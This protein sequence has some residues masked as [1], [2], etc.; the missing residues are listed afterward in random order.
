MINIIQTEPS[1][2][3]LNKNYYFEPKL[4]SRAEANFWAL[5]DLWWK[6]VI[7]PS[8]HHLGRYVFDENLHRVVEE[9]GYYESA[10]NAYQFVGK[11][12]TATLTVGFYKKIHQIACAH[13]D[14]FR[15]NT[16][17]F[18][19]QVG[20]FSRPRSIDS[21]F[22]LKDL[23]ASLPKTEQDKIFDELRNHQISYSLGDSVPSYLSEWYSEEEI[24]IMRRENIEGNELA[25]KWLG[26]F[27]KGLHVKVKKINT[28][29]EEI[30]RSLG[31]GAIPFAVVTLE[32]EDAIYTPGKTPHIH[33][34]Y[35]CE[36]PENLV[37]AAI[38]LFN[39]EI[40][41]VS[42]E[43]K[44]Q[45]IAKLFQTLE[46]LHCYCDGQGRTDLILL[47]KLLC[48]HGFTP[49]IIDPLFASSTVTLDEWVICLKNGMERWKDSLPQN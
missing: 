39:E 15:T 12:L 42:E 19:N 4:K 20:T 9:K 2:S 47:A 16:N 37:K 28:E 14:G 23:F 46:W 49:A 44:L 38:D 43:A 45:A 32:S 1:G 25:A 30:N 10:K 17:L 21:I 3:D 13:F 41:T 29:I 18:A 26:N 31:G 22:P 27:V 40:G 7:D 24:E 36:H 48:Q 11:N 5:G 8:Y 34:K 35:S 6:A 33:I